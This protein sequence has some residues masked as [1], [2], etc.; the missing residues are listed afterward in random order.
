MIIH[1]I[2]HQAIL[3]DI[4]DDIIIQRLSKQIKKIMVGQAPIHPFDD[5]AVGYDGNDTYN[6]YSSSIRQYS[7]KSRSS[8]GGGVSEWK[9]I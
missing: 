8:S 3:I 1:L 2:V 6:S 5:T 7:V 9:I 4:I